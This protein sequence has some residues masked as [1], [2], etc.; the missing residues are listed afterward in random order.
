MWQQISIQTHSEG[1]TSLEALL[2]DNGALAITYIDSEDQPIFQKE[3]GATPLWD[4]VT[5]IALFTNEQD[6]TNLIALLRFQPTVANRDDLE[7]ETVEDEAWERSWMEDFQAMQFGERLWICPSWQSPPDPD[8]VNIML[9]PGLA[10]GSGTHATTAL[11]LEWLEQ[12][13]LDNKEVID[14]GSGSG[15]LAIA[16]ALLGAKRVH[17]VDNDAQA[18]A[19]TMDNSNRNNIGNRLITA[20]LP[21]ALPQL[22]V[23]ILLANILAE[24]LHELADQLAELVAPAGTIVLSGILEEQAMGLMES[25][26]RWFDMEQ[27]TVRQGWVRLVGQRNG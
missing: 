18:I 2:L 19:A 3:P 5:L 1:V 21:D 12:Q 6:L 23:D 20:Y 22:K 27:P 25:Y 11:C 14:Y 24:P 8:A 17:A 4:R 9:D 13:P 15:V 7:V 10:F 26:G 16:A